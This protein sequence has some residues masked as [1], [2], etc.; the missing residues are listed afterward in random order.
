M[1][2][3]SSVTPRPLW[4]W[5][6]DSTSLVHATADA[7]EAVAAAGQNLSDVRARASRIWEPASGL[8]ALDD[9]GDR[10]HIGAEH[11]GDGL[12]D[13]RAV[14]V[15]YGAPPL[16]CSTMRAAI[17][18]QQILK[19]D[20]LAGESPNVGTELWLRSTAADEDVDGAVHPRFITD[21]VGRTGV[22]EGTVDHLLVRSAQQVEQLRAGDAGEALDPSVER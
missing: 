12:D 4:L 20:V 18:I 22:A 10:P 5:S 7:L 13:R 2:F 3:F 1:E 9:L 6:C 21:V 19:H 16:L 15:R 17:T 14:T 8:Q 11:R